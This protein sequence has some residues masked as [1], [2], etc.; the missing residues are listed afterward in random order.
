[1]VCSLLYAILLP[2]AFPATRNIS[3]IYDEAYNPD[4]YWFSAN[5]TRVHC[6]IYIYILQ[7]SALYGAGLEGSP[8]ELPLLCADKGK[9]KFR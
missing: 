3:S 1:M 7:C 2:T 6:S 4:I 9:K 5:K 8:A